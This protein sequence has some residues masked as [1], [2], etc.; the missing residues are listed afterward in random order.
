MIDK[1]LLAGILATTTVVGMAACDTKALGYGDP[2]SIIAVMSPDLWEE[3]E[4]DVYAALETK[5]FTVA[6]EAEFT[7]TYQEPYGEYWNNLR[8]FRQMLLVGTLSD[9]WIQ[10]AI[11][12]SGQDITTP[13]LYRVRDVW[14]LDQ[15]VTLVIAPAGGV[16]AALR[17]H[18]PSVQA[19]PLR[20]SIPRAPCAG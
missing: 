6:E 7:V 18:L 10:E 14:S 16:A 2:N 12:R 17:E 1:R 9:R 3:V 19:R 20:L 13:G 8:R 15:E 5:V 4:D 11:D